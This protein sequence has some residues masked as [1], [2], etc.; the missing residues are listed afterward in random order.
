MIKKFNEMN[1]I[2][3]ESST[4]LYKEK[5]LKDLKKILEFVGHEIELYKA[6]D[7]IDELLKMTYTDVSEWRESILTNYQQSSLDDFI[8]KVIDEYNLNKK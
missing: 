8:V 5:D 2:L 4:K 3:D 6:I 1:E 7:V